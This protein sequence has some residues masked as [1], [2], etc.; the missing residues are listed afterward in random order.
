M[1]WSQCY[2]YMNRV[3]WTKTIPRISHNKK[4]SYYSYKAK[5][6]MCWAVAEPC[7]YQN[8]LLMGSHHGISS[9]K[10]MCIWPLNTPEH[11][12]S[13]KFIFYMLYEVWRYTKFNATVWLISLSRSHD[14]NTTEIVTFISSFTLWHFINTNVHYATRTALFICKSPNQAYLMTWYWFLQGTIPSL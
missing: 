7:K 12:A 10:S 5:K 3:W 1:K 11:K 6:C 14:K 4:L 13:T 2:G 8:N 9:S